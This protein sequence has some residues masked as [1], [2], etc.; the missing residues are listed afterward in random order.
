MEKLP[1]IEKLPEAFSVLADKRITMYQGYAKIIS[2]NQEKIYTVKFSENNYSS[3]DS[4]TYWQGYAGYPILAV[5]MKQG[6]LTVNTDII[7]LFKNIDWNSLNNTHKRD[8]T[9]ALAEVTAKFENSDNIYKELSN[10]Y[11]Q[12]KLLDIN[13]KR[14]KEKKDGFKDSYLMEL[15]ARGELQ[16][17][18]E[19][20][21]K[22]FAE[23]MTPGALNVLGVRVPKVRKLAKEIVKNNPEVYINQ[24]NEMYYEEVLLKGFII[25]NIKGDIDY[26][27]NLVE[28][29]VVKINN[30]ALCDSFCAELKITKN[31]KEVIWKFLQRYIASDLTY[32]IRFAVV[33][34]L[35]YYIEPDYLDR[36]FNK[37]D[38][39]TNDD[40][41][42]QMAVA[43][44]VSV[45][46]VKY[47]DETM[48]YLKNNKLD[49]F[50][51]N[52]AL[53]KIRESLRVDKETKEMIKTM[54]RL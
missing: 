44:A 36:V 50:T 18:A 54:K 43:W 47:Q 6:L 35:D 21:Y 3:N 38:N 52:K 20:K 46:F 34:I 9:K 5:L 28:S 31:N 8:Y 33:M 53:Q 2:S 26:I 42:V 23:K 14:N 30:W 41:Y 27:L 12:F 19:V 13:I 11:E 4:A 10:L 15:K 51:Y 40:Y 29:H 7:N 24:A 37:F 39:I 17:L 16:N 1:P 32:D 22:E 25:A 45:C 48:I 49:K